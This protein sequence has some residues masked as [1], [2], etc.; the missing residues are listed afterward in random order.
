[1]EKLSLKLDF[2]GFIKE[3]QET[4]KDRVYTDFLRRFAYGTD[5]S[6]YRYVP[7]VVIRAFDEAEIRE[8]YSLANKYETQLLL[9]LRVPP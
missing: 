2:E 6:C 1:M 7:R 5:A 4:F 9:E 8:I 3:A